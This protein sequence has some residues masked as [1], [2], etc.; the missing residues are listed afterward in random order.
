MDQFS[1]FNVS[2]ADGIALLRLSRLDKKNA[3][4]QQMLVELEA[5]FASLENATNVQVVILTG[6]ENVFCSGGDIQDWGGL[7][8]QNFALQWLRN[9]H[10]VFDQL[11]QLRHPVIAVVNGPAL[12]GGLEL[13]VC[14][15]YRIAE[16]HSTFGQ[17][18]TG[19]GMIAGWSGTQRASRRFGA[20]VVRR[21]A[22]FGEVFSAAQA[23]DLGIVDQVCESGSG[24]DVAYKLAKNVISKSALATQITK[25]M[26]SVAEG[27]EAD[28]IIDTLA[29]FTAANSQD[30]VEGL[31]AFREKRPPRF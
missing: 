16:Q 25:M 13:A 26:I 12:G 6:Q 24:L 8:A 5:I 10:R 18:E 17:P 30:L 11:A 29:G 3:I 28:R 7:S 21:M 19:L 9:G 2:I 22:I 1:R 31:A 15:D 20:Q 4:D 27:E 14:A 23:L